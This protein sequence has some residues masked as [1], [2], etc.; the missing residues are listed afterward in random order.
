MVVA[1][2]M[3]GASHMDVLCFNCYSK[4]QVG[5]D[6]FLFLDGTGFV[7]GFPSTM[8]G[9]GLDNYKFG[10]PNTRQHFSRSRFE[11]G[12]GLRSIFSR[13]GNETKGRLSYCLLSIYSK[14]GT[15]TLLQFGD[16]AS[17]DGPPGLVIRTTSLVLNVTQYVVTVM[18]ISVCR[19]R[20][21]INPTIFQMRSDHTSGFVFYIGLPYTTLVHTAY[22]A[23]KAELMRYFSDKY[24]W[25]PRTP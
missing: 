6:T 9:C 25:H 21:N 3:L 11:L 19:K 22:T 12:L 4:G 23:V 20:P 15:Y 17:I 16:D 8:F 5:L 10:W 2:T 18:H 24:G 13:Y 14:T 1:C 7:K